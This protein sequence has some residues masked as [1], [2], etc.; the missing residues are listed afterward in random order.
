[1]TGVRHLPRLIL[2]PT[3]RRQTRLHARLFRHIFRYRTNLHPTR[4]N[5]FPN[6]SV[7]ADGVILRP[8]LSRLPTTTN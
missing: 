2:R 3:R 6:Q 4:V 5:L 7:M 1:M 8:Y